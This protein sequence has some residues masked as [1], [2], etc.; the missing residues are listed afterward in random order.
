M[1]SLYNVSNLLSGSSSM[2]LDI[3]EFNDE[4]LDNGLKTFPASQEA[5][6]ADRRGFFLTT[7]ETSPIGS[8]LLTLA[9]WLP[10]YK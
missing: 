4:N 6:K 2:H 7:L 3:A 10:A 9:S 8:P 5:S 1:T